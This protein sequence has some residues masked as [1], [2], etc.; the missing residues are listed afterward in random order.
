MAGHLL[1]FLRSSAAARSSKPRFSSRP[2]FF[3]IV[4]VLALSIIAL[5]AASLGSPRSSIHA[6]TPVK[7]DIPLEL[8]SEVREVNILLFQI[9]DLHVNTCISAALSTKPKTNAPSSKPIAL[10]TKS[11]SCPTSSYTTATSPMQ[12]RLRLPSSRYGW[13]Y[14][15]APSALPPAT[16]SA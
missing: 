11:A 8:E 2:F 15:S 4:T 7:R 3:V 13:H 10:T 9:W 1:S 14:F 16:S 6:T 12:S 5:V